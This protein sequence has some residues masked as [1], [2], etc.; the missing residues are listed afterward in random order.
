[1]TFKQASAFIAKWRPVLCP[2]WEITVKAGHDPRKPRSEYTA[3]IDPQGDYLKA[4]LYLGDVV[5]GD[6]GEREDQRV[7]LHELL[8]LTLWDLDHAAME[9][10]NALG[11]E[12]N[13]LAKVTIEHHVERT[14]DRLADVLVDAAA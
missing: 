14:V 13:K 3:T 2:E 5:D 12:A 7:L 4:T 9:V 8:H 10:A 11:Y 6:L 1:M